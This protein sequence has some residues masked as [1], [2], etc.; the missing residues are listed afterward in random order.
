[1]IKHH[2]KKIF[3]RPFLAKMNRLAR[4]GIPDLVDTVMG[5]REPMVPPKRLIFI[6]GPL[7]KEIGDEHFRIFKTIGGL[8]P[9]DVVL[10]VGCGIGRMARPLTPF[11][12]GS[13]RYEGF[14][15][16]S[17]GIEW[18][19]KNITT[20]FRNFRFQTADIFNK[21][22]NPKGRF[23]GAE[24]R[25]PYE[26]STFDFIFLTSVFTHM[27]PDELE[28]YMGEIS[29]VLK[30]GGR[31]LINFFLWNPEALALSNGGKS[32]IQFPFEFENYRVRDRDFPEDAVTYSERFILELFEKKDLAVQNPIQYGNWCGR[33]KALSYQDFVLAIKKQD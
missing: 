13:G 10:D 2:L 30:P 4:F 1:M 21:Y 26:D 15:I 19:R 9:G 28:N 29:R 17:A 3:P 31:C 32:S 6:G 7:F 11:L 18:C 12:S 25:F 33:E 16:D 20:R 5:R 22:Y 23:K 27:L 24:Y 14:D 8:K